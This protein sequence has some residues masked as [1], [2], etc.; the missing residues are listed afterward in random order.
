MSYYSTMGRSPDIWIFRFRTFYFED[1]TFMQDMVNSEITDRDFAIQIMY[2]FLTAP[3]ISMQTFSKLKDV[4]LLDLSAQWGIEHMGLCVWSKQILSLSEFQAV[5]KRKM[6]YL[7]N[8]HTYNFVAHRSQKS[9]WNQVTFALSIILL[10]PLLLLIEIIKYL[11]LR[12]EKRYCSRYYAYIG[13]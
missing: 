10:L 2:H 3:T 1:L 9:W 4:E 12:S 11:R 5:I 6:C 13:E 8:R 7:S